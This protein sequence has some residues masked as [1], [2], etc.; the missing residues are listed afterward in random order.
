MI[1]GVKIAGDGSPGELIV[2]KM[3]LRAK[4]SNLKLRSPRHFVPRDDFVGSP[5]HFVPR[6]DDVT[7]FSAFILASVSLRECSEAIR[8]SRREAS[9]MPWPSEKCH[10]E[11]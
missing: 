11:R 2:R 4:R 1:C 7:I 3:S 5:R 9:K 10:C 6:D 8:R